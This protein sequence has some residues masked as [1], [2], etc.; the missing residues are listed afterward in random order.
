ML[1]AISTLDA[2]FPMNIVQ[3]HRSPLMKTTFRTIVRV[4]ADFRRLLKLG[5][6]PFAFLGLTAEQEA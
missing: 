6:L 4:F 3:V 1:A 2:S 5:Q